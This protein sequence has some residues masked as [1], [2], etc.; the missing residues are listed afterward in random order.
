MPD[1]AQTQFDIRCE[2][3][4]QGLEHLAPDS[5]VVIIVD[6]LSFSTCV[7]V[8]VS[9]GA[10]IYPYRGEDAAQFARERGALLAERSRDAEYTLSPASLQKIPAGTKLVLPSPNGSTLSF[11][12]GDTPTLAGC[13]RNAQAVAAA[14]QTLGKRISVIPAG[15]RWWTDY[16]LR[17]SM[18]DWLGA[19]AILSA[20]RGN[21]SIEARA[22]EQ[23]FLAFQTK[24]PDVLRTIASG[25]ELVD[26]GFAEDVQI[27][28][29]L[30][31]SQTVPHLIDGAYQSG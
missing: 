21:K 18:E 5:D 1:F 4:L 20:L 12:T 22:A 19:G 8:A 27:A 6:V 7:D 11:A 13:L 14:A 2:W 26:G 9:N 31:V 3:G 25:I 28:A 10:L 15:E 30:N 24:L 16:S 23:V 29:S 17:P